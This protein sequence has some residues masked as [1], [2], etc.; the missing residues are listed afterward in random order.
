MIE[1]VVYLT[2]DYSLNE[3]IWVN[4][5]LTREQITQTVSDKFPIWYYYD[6]V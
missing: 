5:D 2:K 4:A 3:S 1:V 6:I